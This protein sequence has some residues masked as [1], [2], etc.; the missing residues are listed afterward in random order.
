MPSVGH[1]RRAKLGISMYKRKP[2]KNQLC[3]LKKLI[4]GPMGP[5]FEPFL[6]SRDRFL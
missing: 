6:Y 1:W 2:S 5:L 3:V 4:K